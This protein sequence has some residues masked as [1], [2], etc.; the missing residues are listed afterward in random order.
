MNTIQRSIA[1]VLAGGLACT[2]LPS[3]AQEPAATGHVLV[4][5]NER[6]LEG[7]IVRDGDEYCIRHQGGETT[8]PADRVFA[9][10]TDMHDAYNRLHGRSNLMDPDERMHLAQWCHFHGLHAEAIAELQATLRLDPDRIQARRTLHALEQEPAA[11]KPTV[12]PSRST[13]PDPPIQISAEE[14]GAFTTRIQPILMNTCIRC[15]AQ[16]GAGSFRLT[17][18]FGSPGLTQLATRH[19]LAATLMQV[20]H[21]QPSASPLLVKALSLHGTADRPPL[22]DRNTLAYRI[23]EDWVRRQRAIPPAVEAAEVA[24]RIPVSPKE[25]IPAARVAFTAPA[26]ATVAD[27]DATFAGDR[28]G[29][30]VQP[31]ADQAPADPFDP[32]LF[33]RMAHPEK[34]STSQP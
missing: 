3:H 30:P 12:S 26:S 10:C 27:T 24:S 28:K 16:E 9:L 21:A 34:V 2:A 17:R 6:T 14:V 29:F 19:N 20:N 23:L 7:D 8:L 31:T 18:V 33:N 22:K 25:T 15:H 32:A 1:A 13:V 11:S 5:K 4:L